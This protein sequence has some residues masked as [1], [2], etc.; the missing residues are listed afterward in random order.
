MPKNDSNS[1]TP[2]PPAPGADTP[3][4]IDYIGPFYKKKLIVPG[5]GA[6]NP[7]AMKEADIRAMVKKYPKL[8]R[9]WTG[10]K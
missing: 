8:A 9:L 2:A 6:I 7:K 3:R 1:A 4:T 5:A 10:L